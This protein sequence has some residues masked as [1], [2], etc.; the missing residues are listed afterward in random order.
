MWVKWC[1]QPLALPT[2]QAQK[3][4]LLSTEACHLS[5][6]DGQSEWAAAAEGETSDAADCSCCHSYCCTAV[7]GRLGSDIVALVPVMLQDHG[8][9]QWEVGETQR[10]C[11]VDDY[12]RTR[13]IVA[14]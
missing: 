11:D 3:N 13:A 12:G 10:C 8:W 14:A 7:L 9:D 2:E 5:T 6:A 4:K 1:F